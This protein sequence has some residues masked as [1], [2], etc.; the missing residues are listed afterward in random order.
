MLTRSSISANSNED[1]ATSTLY[2]ALRA[3]DGEAQSKHDHLPFAA[4]G[5]GKCGPATIAAGQSS[6]K[7]MEEN[8][9][10]RPLIMC[11]LRGVVV[12]ASG[13]LLG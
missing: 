3:E 6:C 13:L 1:C 9:Y 12:C 11:V 8:L 10:S 2:L 5:L 4:N 7:E